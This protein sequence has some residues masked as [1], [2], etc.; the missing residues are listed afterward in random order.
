MFNRSAKNLTM[1]VF[2]SKQTENDLIQKNMVATKK[3]NTE[4]K[5]LKASTDSFIQEITFQQNQLRKKFSPDISRRNNEVISP[6][7]M[8]RSTSRQQHLAPGYDKTR[9][10]SSNAIL[11]DRPI[12]SA[13]S[14]S[15][16][17]RTA[18]PVPGLPQI[19]VSHSSSKL[20][21]KDIQSLTGSNPRASSPTVNRDIVFFPPRI[22]IDGV[23][24]SPLSEANIHEEGNLHLP[25]VRSLSNSMPNVFDDNQFLSSTPPISEFSD[26]ETNLQPMSRSR[27]GSVVSQR[28]RSRNIS[29]DALLRDLWHGIPHVELGAESSS[30]WTPQKQLD[31][32]SLRSCR[33][34]RI[35][36]ND[37]TG[38]DDAS[39]SVSV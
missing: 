28:R 32:D 14:G 21:F 31:W 1:E 11:I 8:R 25:I 12:M 27:S 18:T 10:H 13:C 37:K 39:S 35:K 15:R 36:N 3:L 17:S 6:A 26:I 4:I 9:P 16:S 24:E 22:V 30:T 23:K 19:M 7:N 38:N 33:Y 34:L 2:H 29:M 20:S 5:K